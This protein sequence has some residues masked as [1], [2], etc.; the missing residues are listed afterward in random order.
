MQPMAS[1]TVEENM[2]AEAARVVVIN[3]T[4]VAGMAEKT[5]NY[6][7]AQ[8]MNVT[9]FGN[10]SDYPDNYYQPLPYRTILIVHSGK[11]YA[12]QYLMGLMK[13]DS[14]SQIKVDFNP[15]APEDILVALGSD[16]VSNNPMP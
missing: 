15:D 3:D 7:K 2:Q 12:M 10:I 8:G 1:G 11:P 5:F 9:G 6:L 13:F 14:T 16:W 4:G